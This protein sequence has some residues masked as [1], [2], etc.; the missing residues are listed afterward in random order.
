MSHSAATQLLHYFWLYWFLSKLH[1]FRY[2]LINIHLLFGC[3]ETWATQLPLVIQIEKESEAQ[4]AKESEC[5]SQ[6]HWSSALSSTWPELWIQQQGC[7]GQARP[8][9]SLADSRD[10]LKEPDLQQ[11]SKALKQELQQCPC[12]LQG[13]IH[14]AV[15]LITPHV[16]HIPLLL[17]D[18]VLLWLRQISNDFVAQMTLFFKVQLINRI[19]VVPRWVCKLTTLLIIQVAWTLSEK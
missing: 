15:D 4:P 12:W 8:P 19:C 6:A 2:P 10:L 14:T 1:Q 16:I 7:P 18:A 13:L 17:L 9:R 3:S 11:G 5:Q